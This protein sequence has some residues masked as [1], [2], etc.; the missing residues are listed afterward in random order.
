MLGYKSGVGTLVRK[1]VPSI[2]LW[3]CLNHRL[4]LAVNDSSNAVSGVNYIQ[5]I[6]TKVYSV[7]S[8][9]PKL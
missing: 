9:P 1:D 3:H 7:Y 8:M 6:F 5:A 2:I 4:E